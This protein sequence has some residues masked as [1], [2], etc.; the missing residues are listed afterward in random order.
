MSYSWLSYIF[1]YSGSNSALQDFLIA[2]VLV[3]ETGFAVTGFMA[4]FL[5]LVL[6]EGNC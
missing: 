4:L 5:N 6:P 3:P 1:T 2:I